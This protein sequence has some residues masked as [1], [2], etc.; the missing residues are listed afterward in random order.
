MWNRRSN[1]DYGIVIVVEISYHGW[2]TSFGDDTFEDS[3]YA[4]P[5]CHRSSVPELG[6]DFII[7][8]SFFFHQDHFEN[9]KSDV[10]SGV[11]SAY[12]FA[13]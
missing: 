9:G 4:A 2:F 12:H 6:F 8:S 10:T 5:P 11:V 1:I 3:V 7:L 13:C